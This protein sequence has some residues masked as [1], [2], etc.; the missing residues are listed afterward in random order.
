[1]VMKFRTGDEI[2]KE[3]DE[4]VLEKNKDIIVNLIE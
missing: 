2:K 4:I 3:L 1:M